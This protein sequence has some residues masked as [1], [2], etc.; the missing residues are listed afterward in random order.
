MARAMA[1]A[2][3]VD[4]L[5]SIASF[6][7][8][9]AAPARRRCRPGREN[10]AS[11][12]PPAIQ[13]PTRSPRLILS[14]ACATAR[15]PI[16]RWRTRCALR[17]CAMRRYTGIGH[18]GSGR[19]KNEQHGRTA[20]KGHSAVLEAGNDLEAEHLV[21]KPFRRCEIARVKRGFA[22]LAELHERECDSLPHAARAGCPVA[23]FEYEF[24]EMPEIGKMLV[25]FGAVIALDRARAL[26]RIR[27]RLVR[28][29][30][31]G[32]P[33]RAGTFRFL[34]SDRHLHHHQ[35]CGQRAPL[36]FPSL[37][38]WP[39]ARNN[40]HDSSAMSRGCATAG[41]AP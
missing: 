31:G 33:D 8:S 16:R 34:F 20:T 24:K 1:L 12:R 37:G 10:R 25:V 26:E 40:K 2:Y 5:R 7:T 4:G 30:A 35:H 9:S 3:P 21:I 38:K 39:S 6:S 17:Q 22:E 41:A 29:F 11:A 23:A 19:I 32:Y 13:P 36:S 28:T 27:S 15:S 18:A 14:T